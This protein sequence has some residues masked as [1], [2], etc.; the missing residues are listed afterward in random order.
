MTKIKL[1]DG[2]IINAE[3]VEIV[4]GVLEISMKD[5]TVEELAEIFSEKGKTNLIILMTESEIES[6]YQKG[7]TSFAG[8]RYGSD[9]LK[10]VQ[11]FQPADVT[12]AR[13]SSAEGTANAA[14]SMA[15]S[16][17][18]TAESSNQMVSDLSTK[19]SDLES[20]LTNTQLAV[21]E[22][23]ELIAGGAE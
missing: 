14:N 7:F 8:I 20:E 19:N 13:I 6:G 23:A 12:E 11:L 21:A 17:K 16:A 5:H 22:L 9:G 1:V 18:T 15:E 3:T 10:T 4:N 2:T